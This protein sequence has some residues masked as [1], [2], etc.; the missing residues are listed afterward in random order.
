MKM[1]SFMRSIFLHLERSV[2]CF[3]GIFSFDLHDNKC[4]KSI[5]FQ[6]DLEDRF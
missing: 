2:I 4:I 1:D 3:C 6:K 5:G